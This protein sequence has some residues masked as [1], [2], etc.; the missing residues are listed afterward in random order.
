MDDIPIYE[1]DLSNTISK[2][3]QSGK[4]TQNSNQNN[5]HELNNLSKSENQVTEWIPILF[6]ALVVVYWIVLLHKYSMINDAIN[7]L[8]IQQ[9]RIS[10]NEMKIYGSLMP[11]LYIITLGLCYSP[12]GKQRVVFCQVMTWLTILMIGFGIGIW[13]I[14]SKIIKDC[15]DEICN[16]SEAKHINNYLFTLLGCGLI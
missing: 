3:N 11:L 13:W 10:L 1:T 4:S 2:E 15:V 6:C 7:K 12:I 14:S 16:Y 8:D 9:F 5:E